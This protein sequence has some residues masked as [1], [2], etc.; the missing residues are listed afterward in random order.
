MNIPGENDWGISQI[1]MGGTYT[2]PAGDS[3]ILSLSGSAGSGHEFIADFHGAKWSDSI[4]DSAVSGYWHDARSSEP[5]TG[6]YIGETVGT[7]N[8]ADYTWQAA[9][10]GVWLETDRL[11]QMASTAD[12]RDKLRQLNI[13]A[14]EVGRTDLSGSLLRG[15]AGEFD[16]ISVFMDDVIFFAPSTGQKPG[17]WATNS[18]SGQYDFSHGQLT[19]ANIINPSN[20]VPLSGGGNI[21]ADFQFK[22]WNTSENTWTST[23]QNGSGTLSGGS[24]NGTVNFTGTAA[25]AITGTP[26]TGNLDGTGAGLVN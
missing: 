23:I 22:N 21:R 9:V 5:F 3:W 26:S 25:G 16:Y 11:L 7:F 17:I 20:I 13:P 24:Y 1:L 19:T 6:I 18:I 15:Q 12:G 4:T 2:D 8:P 14:V 10:S